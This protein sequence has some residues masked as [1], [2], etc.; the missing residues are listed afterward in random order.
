MGAFAPVAQ[1]VKGR[2]CGQTEGGACRSEG[3][4]AGEHVPDRL[5]EAAG[6]V[7]LGDLRSA[8]AAKARIRPLVALLVDGMPGGA[9]RRLEQRPAQVARAR[10]CQR[11]AAV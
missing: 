11:A 8:L 7:D 4:V 5:A 10:L 1:F 9:D 2:L 6:N 3:L